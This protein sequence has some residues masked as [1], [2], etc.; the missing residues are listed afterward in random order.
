MCTE[1]QRQVA[2]RDAKCGENKRP[3]LHIESYH[4]CHMLAEEKHC[5]QAQGSKKTK[6][7]VLVEKSESGCKHVEAHTGEDKQEDETGLCSL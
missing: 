5:K 1:K 7:N 6:D 4:T 2:T 3:P